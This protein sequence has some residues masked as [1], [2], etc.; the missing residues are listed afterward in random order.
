L[1]GSQIIQPAQ[2]AEDYQLIQ[3]D[4]LN[5]E[6]VAEEYFHK[7]ENG[8]VEV[9]VNITNIHCSACVWL[10]EKVLKETPGD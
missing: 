8:A 7:L 2:S 10:N 9:F 3:E 6:L 1:R 5:G 4:Y